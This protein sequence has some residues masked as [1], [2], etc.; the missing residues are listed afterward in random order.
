MACYLQSLYKC[1]ATNHIC[2]NKTTVAQNGQVADH[3]VIMVP[4]Q[5]E[6]PP[7]RLDT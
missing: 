1:K 7:R 6:S 3:I 5:G 2:M 4:R